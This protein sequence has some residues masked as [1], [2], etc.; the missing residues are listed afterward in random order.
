MAY[1]IVIALIAVFFVLPA[2]LLF[3]R[4]EA[5]ARELW[6]AAEALGRNEPMSLRPYIDAS[7]CI[8][9]ATCVRACPEGKILRVVD[10]HA[11]FVDGSHCVGHGACAAACPTSAIELVFG[12]ERRGVD[13]PDVN[14]EFMSNVPGL[15]IAGEL[16]GMGL[17]ANA[18]K[19]GTEAVEYIAK[20]I[21]KRD[22]VAH[23][24]IIVGAGPAGI[25]AGLR[26][27]E[28]GLSAVIL[29]QDQFGGAIRH[30]PRQKL[31]TSHGFTL[32]GQPTVPPGTLLK[33]ELIAILERAVEASGL[34]IAEKEGVLAVEKA[35][36][37]FDVQT[38]ERQIRATR[39]LLTVGR[40]GTP[41]RLEV[42]GE[43]REK[44]VYRLLEPE[45]FQH[46]HVLVVGGGDSALEAAVALSKQAGTRV[47][48]SYRKDV[49]SRA[50][51]VND[52]AVKAAADAGKVR[53]LL[54]S[55]VSS[56][57]IDRVTLDVQGAEEVVANDHVFVFAGGVLPT[58]FLQ[59]AGI[60]V[61][62]HFGK[63][64]EKLA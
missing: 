25:A 24:L 52:A 20:E 63:R 49:F 18:V 36:E 26:A 22:D 48:L 61:E 23:D 16:G 6:E 58:A 54:N 1:A 28:L 14:P 37:G 51:A 9:C 60:S 46:S 56:I 55:T 47:T 53:M 17:I 27:Q 34:P 2:Y 45:N 11:K 43:E 62:R 40:R 10:G 19:Q 5:E 32:P 39:V 44:V 7:Q 38:T 33:E 12:S 3:R 42:P 30:Y 35:A 57:G 13:L 8:G 59:S 50:N 31:V 64:R 4:E 41:R 21:P 29:E 15:Y